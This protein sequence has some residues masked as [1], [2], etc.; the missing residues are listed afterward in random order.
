MSVPFVKLPIKVLK[1]RQLS[2]WAR[3]LYSLIADYQTD[4]GAYPGRE[5]MA[6]D[7]GTSVPTVDRAL[8]EL[9]AAG[10]IK[11][12]RQGRGHTNRY[13]LT[14]DL[15]PVTTQSSDE[16]SPVI[17]QTTDDLSR[18]TT[19]DLSP[20][21]TPLKEVKPDLEEPESPVVPEEKPAPKKPKEIP[22]DFQEFWSKYPGRNGR[23]ESKSDSLDLWR[24]MPAADRSAALA[25][26]GSYARSKTAQDGYAVDAIRWLRRKR[27][28]D[29][30]AD[31]GSNGAVDWNDPVAREA[32]RKQA[33]RDMLKR[34]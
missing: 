7:L 10:L 11:R 5:R 20:V 2:P 25:A 19:P 30:V 27:W 29:E 6:D 34:L 31:Q 24:K 13:F 22:A 33:E 21:I 16:L 1:N 26:V 17:T 28:T 3:L 15:S 8:A 4:R 12:H 14:D 23:K 32:H 18:V 9:S